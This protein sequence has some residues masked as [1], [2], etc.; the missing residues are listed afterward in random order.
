M[1]DESGVISSTEIRKLVGVGD[2]EE[3]AR[4]LGHRYSLHGPVMHGD[5]RGRT[6][7]IP[8]ANIDYSKDKVIPSKGIYACW[9]NIGTEKF[10]TMTNIGTNPTFTPDKQTPN[11]EAYLLDFDR[12][13]YE[14]DI[15]VEF[16]QRLRDELKFSSVDALLEQIRLDVQK[17]R[18]I[19][20]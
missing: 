1:S 17:G 16:V 9:V 18:E 11:V 13:L 2:V 3:A 14:Q 4:L 15:K 7:G 19:L 6:I 20:R 5:G 12:D 10:R 8:T